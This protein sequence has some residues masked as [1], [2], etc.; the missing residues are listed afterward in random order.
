MCPGTYSYFCARSGYVAA[1]MIR[2]VV[3]AVGGVVVPGSGT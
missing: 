3:T 1:R 2:L